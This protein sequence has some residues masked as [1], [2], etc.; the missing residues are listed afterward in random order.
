[1][2]TDLQKF[3]TKLLSL[4]VTVIMSDDQSRDNNQRQK[5]IRRQQR[6]EK[7]LIRMYKERGLNV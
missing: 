6:L 1:M 4:I 3:K 5:L 7:E 2:D